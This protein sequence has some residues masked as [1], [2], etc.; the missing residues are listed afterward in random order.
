MS[1]PAMISDP[2]GSPIVLDGALATYLESLGADISGALWSAQILLSNPDLIYQAHLDYYRAGADVVITA[3]YQA[4]IPGLQRHLNLS[5]DESS[6][7]IRKSV[8]LA[9]KARTDYLREL[10]RHGKSKEKDS[11]EKRLLVAGSVGPYGA[12]LA[13]G[14][15]YRGDYMVTKEAMKAFHRDRIKVLVE[16]GA[17]LLACETMPS[18]LEVKALVELLREDFGETKTWFSFT[19][20]GEDKISDGTSLEQVVQA[21]EKSEQ[22]VALGVNC[23][24]EGH[25]LGALKR[26]SK[27]TSKPLVVYSNSGEQWDADSRSWYGSR[28]EGSHLAELTL[29]WRKAGAMLI[30]GC[31]RTTPQ[32]ISIVDT[33]LRGS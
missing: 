27:L 2:E 26:L 25:A 10:A 12:Y 28:T 1:A 19:L 13:D 9:Q 24:P 15:E 3:S 22:V 31:C 5:V 17:D 33:T 23:I 4:S 16:A 6:K 20:R 32:D 29:E 30:G 21:L 18:M 7:M 11:K 8:E 14:S